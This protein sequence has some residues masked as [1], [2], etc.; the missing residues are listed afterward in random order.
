MGVAD[1]V[2][3]TVAG[4]VGVDVLTALAAGGITAGAGVEA[5]AG[6]KITISSNAKPD[7]VKRIGY[8]Y[9][10]TMMS[11][12][13]SDISRAYLRQRKVEA[14]APTIDINTFDLY[15]AA[16]FLYNSTHN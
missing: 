16:Q 8:F 4:R 2:G 13:L 11:W 12:R 6:K 7:K 14:T 5:Q 10:E 1:G 15:S 3:V 9:S